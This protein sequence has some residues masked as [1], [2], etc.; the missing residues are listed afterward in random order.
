M[1]FNKSFALG[2]VAALF[3]VSASADELRLLAS[4]PENHVYSQ[5][6]VVPFMELVAKK[7]NGGTTIVL[8]GPDVVPGFE[9]IEPVQ[10][11]V[12]DFVFTHPAY[13]A[14]TAPMGL[15]ID[16]IK[17]DPTARRASGVFDAIDAYYQGH[18]LK[19]IAMPPGGSVA[20]NFVLKDP[21]DGAPS[22]DGR[23][24]RG[25]P[26]YN[27]VIEALGGT[28]VVLG[29]PDIYSSLQT[30]VI[31]GAATTL[32]GVRDAKWFEVAG[33]LTRPA[34]GQVS[35]V[36]LMNLDSWTGLSADQQ[37][38]VTEAAIE[39]ELLSTASFDRLAAEEEKDLLAM[40]MK[41]THMPAEDAD[42]LDALWEAGA[43]SNAMKA[44]D[45]TTK[46]LE[47]SRSAGLSK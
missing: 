45:V 22:L 20:F 16:G 14:G 43:W 36:I 31:D 46:L 10:A 17:A 47:L 19:L 7:T 26:S 3:A 38:L 4:W 28:P 13:H 6:S 8:S 40:G 44:G 42:R 29:M 37:A 23:K 18:G 34:F 1:K 25:T 32:T 27:P 30:G 5:E 12:F 24:I 35:P 39:A 2:A 21:V 41:I 11:G 9:Q 15:A 33:Y